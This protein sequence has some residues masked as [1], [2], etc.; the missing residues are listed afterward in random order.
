MVIFSPITSG[1]ELR[2]GLSIEVILPPSIVSKIQSVEEGKN[3]D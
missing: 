3:V 2:V 1:V